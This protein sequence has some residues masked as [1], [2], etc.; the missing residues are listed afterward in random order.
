MTLYSLHTYLLVVP[1]YKV[2]EAPTDT[3][4]EKLVQWVGVAT[5]DLDLGKDVELHSVG[6]CVGLDL[7]RGPWLLETQEV[8]SLN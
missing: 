8:M 2:S 4:L 1:L 6:C 7:L 3:R 5:V